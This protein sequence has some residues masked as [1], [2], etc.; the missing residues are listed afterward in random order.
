MMLPQF[1]RPSVKTIRFRRTRLAEHIS[2]YPLFEALRGEW[3]VDKLKPIAKAI[4]YFEP[5]FEALLPASRRGNQWAKS[6]WLEN[7]E[8]RGVELCRRLEI[9]D[10]RRAVRDVALLMNPTTRLLG[11]NFTE[12][13]GGSRIT[14]GTIEFRRSAGANEPAE[15]LAYAEF[16]TL[17]I[18]SAQND[19]L[20]LYDFEITIE[21]LRSLVEMQDCPPSFK[22]Y[23][24]LMDGKSG[25]RHPIPYLIPYL[26]LESNERRRDS[27]S[28][29]GVA[30]D[31]GGDGELK[32]T[33]PRCT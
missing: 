21:G 13:I 15:V 4:Q 17:F 23:M 18:N 22:H 33:L 24:L 3:T 7:P 14:R 11:W 30:G 6:N 12:L 28:N 10:E 29:D 26:I 20:D 2:I 5:A 25:S 31:A 16:I 1:G 27:D 32:P 8:L 19:E 9:I